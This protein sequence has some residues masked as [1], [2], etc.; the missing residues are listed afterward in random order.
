MKHI[1]GIYDIAKNTNILLDTDHNQQKGIIN[2]INGGLSIIP[3]YYV[4]NGE[5]VDIW[6]AEDMKEMLTDEYFAKQTIKDKQ[7][8]QKLKELLKNLKEDDNPVIVIAK[9]K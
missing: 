3:R 1:Y 4:G 2:D 7:A 6:R 9:M 8:H 5:V